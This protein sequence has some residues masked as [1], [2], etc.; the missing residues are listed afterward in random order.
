MDGFECATTIR[1]VRQFRDREVS[2]E[3]KWRVLEAGRLTGSG[4]NTQ[5]WRFI[6]VEGKD[7]LRQLAEDSIT[8]KWVAGADFAVILVT[9][10]QLGFHKIDAG[11]C[12]QSMQLAAWNSGVVSCIFTGIDQDKTKR[13]FEI[14]EELEVSAVVGFGHPA[15][16]IT[17]RKKS[18]R[19]LD[20]VAFLDAFGQRLDAE[21]LKKPV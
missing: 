19:P 17:G 6:L 10:P 20:E 3:I 8:G 1:D 9:D 21:T 14:P 18:R 15:Q 11:R 16:K 4:K 7:R 5:H 12:L 13:D 2:N